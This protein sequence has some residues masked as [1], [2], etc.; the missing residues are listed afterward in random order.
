VLVC[1]AEMKHCPRRS[2]SGQS[3]GTNRWVGVFNVEVYVEERVGRPSS[4]KCS[5]VIP[6]DGMGRDESQKMRD[7]VTMS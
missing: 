2:Q 5:A 4:G 1:Y 7:W 6:L 3:V